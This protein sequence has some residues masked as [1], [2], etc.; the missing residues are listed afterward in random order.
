MNKPY[1]ISEEEGKLILSTQFMEDNNSTTDDSGS[2]E[3]SDELNTS[4]DSNIES[5]KSDNSELSD[6]DSNYY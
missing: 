4:D 1:C 5:E 2:S 3:D 6:C